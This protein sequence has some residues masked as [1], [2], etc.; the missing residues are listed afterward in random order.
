MEPYNSKQM[1][2]QYIYYHLE[3]HSQQYT[4]AEIYLH[5]LSK[6][7]QV[8]SASTASADGTMRNAQATT[9]T[10]FTSSGVLSSLSAFFD[11]NATISNT[12]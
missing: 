6:H 9:P 8:F 12:P 1:Q 10:S 2:V 3:A 4:D 5:P 11:V 7:A